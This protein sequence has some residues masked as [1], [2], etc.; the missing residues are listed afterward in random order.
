MIRLLIYLGSALM[1]YN[2]IGFIK[3]A[4]YVRRLKT[5]TASAAI[6]H[7][8]I[9]LLVLFLLGYLAVGFLGKPDLIVSGILFGGSIF[10][11]VM[12]RLLKGVTQ[13]IMENEKLE[14]ELM[15]LEESSHAKAS[16]LASVSH[17]MRTPLNV[18]IGLDN[19][20]LNDP[21]LPQSIHEKLLKIRLSA[22]HLLGLINNILE[23]NRAESGKL[24]LKSET[25]RLSDELEQVNAIAQALCDEKGLEYRTSVQGLASGR[26][27]GDAVQ[28]K[29]VLLSILE[30]AVKYTDAP[31]SVRF[32]VSCDAQ[33]EAADTLRF[34]VTDT[35]I[36]ISPEFL[37]KMFSMFAQ[38]DDSSTSR[39][40]GSGLSLALSKQ[41]VD[42]MGGK[43]GA[44]SE[45]NVGS[46]FTVTVSLPRDGDAEPSAAPADAAGV[47]LEGR[48]I[49]LAEDIPENAEIVTDL[50]ELEG[51]EADHAENGQRALELF[52][53]S[54]PGYYDAILMD[55][56]MP[57]MDGFEATR[58]IRALDR[59]DAETIPIVALTANAF[60]EDVRRTLGAG[61][62]KHLAKPAEA[63][64]LYETL[65]EQIGKAPQAGGKTE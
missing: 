8:P 1:V 15:A 44:Q 56:R 40:G 51:V 5:W 18:I 58:L 36:G 33:G 45:K 39:F 47:S 27:V 43:I 19:A 3:F 14:I 21:S 59:P 60:A 2:I 53:Q 35:G 62:N 50:L 63:D 52:S 12:Y 30:N 11:F 32:D 6:L 16:F 24:T 26:Y 48:R 25:F 9:V 38:E 20:A 49:L 10:V 13:H 46:T 7:F 61:M 42:L 31:G 64:A 29:N 65:R 4:R 41:I 54:P 34:S 17:E 55:L 57:V 37:P 22:R 23:L 28:L